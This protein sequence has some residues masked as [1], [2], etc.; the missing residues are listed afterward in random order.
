MENIRSSFDTFL[1]A[2]TGETDSRGG[3]SAPLLTS[4]PE[5]LNFTSSCFSFLVCVV[6]LMPPRAVRVGRVDMRKALGNSPGHREA[7]SA[8]VIIPL[9]M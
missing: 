5:L 2:Q 4:D 6:E 1:R 3:I 9:L 8:A 7:L